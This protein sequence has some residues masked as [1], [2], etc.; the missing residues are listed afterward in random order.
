M[1]H[2]CTYDSQT[3]AANGETEEESRDTGGIIM[4]LSVCFLSMIKTHIEAATALTNLVSIFC[5]DDD[6]DE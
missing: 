3:E 1:T 2:M 5:I 4:D 6:D